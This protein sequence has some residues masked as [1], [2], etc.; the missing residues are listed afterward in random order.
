MVK[1]V[2]ILDLAVRHVPQRLLKHE[3]GAPLGPTI[4][5]LESQ[6]CG[7]RPFLS[8]NSQDH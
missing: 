4:V 5:F 3:G 2:I 6:C 7:L 1:A 8:P